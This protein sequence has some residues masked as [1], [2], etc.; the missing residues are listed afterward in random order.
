MDSNMLISGITLGTGVLMLLGSC[1]YTVRK[2]TVFRASILTTGTVK[3]LKK[4]GTTA[5]VSSDDDMLF[6]EEENIFKGGTLA[7]VVEFHDEQGRVFEFTGAGSSPP[8]YK[9][10]DTVKILY[11]RE[12]PESAVIDSFFSKWFLAVFLLSFSTVFLSTGLLLMLLLP[13]AG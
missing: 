9:P 10:G 1:W 6:R 4:S 8:R 3:A 13:Q 11:T 7:P 2:I 12:N 5:F